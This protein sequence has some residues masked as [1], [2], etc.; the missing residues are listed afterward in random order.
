MSFQAM[1]WAVKQKA[2]SAGAKL[3]L[4]MLADHSN[5]HTGQCNPSHKRLAEECEMSLSALKVHI[6][7]L[8]RLGL[9]EII[10]KSQDGVSLPNQYRLNLE[11]VGQNLA[12]GGSES[13][14]GVGQNLATNQEDKPGSEPYTASPSVGKPDASRN[15][16]ILS[17]Y[18]EELG[19]VLQKATK[20]SDKRKKAIN[21]RWSEYINTM[22]V[23]GKIR[24]TDEPSGVEWFRRVFR[25]VK[26]NPHWIGDSNAQWRADFDWLMN[27]NNF[28]KVVEY[29]PARQ[30]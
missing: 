26:L 27:P 17:A 10:H 15:D 28:L 22:G 5:G 29:A 13:D 21:A 19:D 25:K 20:L 16:L 11:G 7:N 8:E 1:T 6:K 23:N 18:N 24:F 30:S 14:R 9:L 12:G 4:L 3:V 2:Q